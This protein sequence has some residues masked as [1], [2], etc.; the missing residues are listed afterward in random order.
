MRQVFTSPR[1]ENVE[2][3]AALLAEHEIDTYIS[4]G[5]SYKGTRRQPFSYRD[6]HGT[7]QPAVWVVKAE[8]QPRARELLRG[9]G[10][11]GTTRPGSVEPMPYLPPARTGTGSSGIAVRIR[12]LVLVAVVMGAVM[13]LMRL[14]GS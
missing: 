1:L 14:Q 9:A 11:L 5:R 8:D 2:S 4:E 3:V 13:L 6:R 12:L 10:L 7:P